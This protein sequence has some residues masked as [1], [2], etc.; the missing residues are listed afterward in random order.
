M[1]SLVGW[2]RQ[3]IGLYLD[4]EGDPAAE[5]LRFQKEMLG[6]DDFR[7][8][9]AADSFTVDDPVYSQSYILAE[10][11][12]KQILSAIRSQVEGPLWPNPRFAGWLT[13]NWLRYGTRH[14]WIPWDKEVTGRPFGA[15]AF[16]RGRS[17]D[18]SV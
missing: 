13:E 6:F 4:P 18:R 12:D 17:F 11:F 14:D 9:S 10:L 15:E 3:E 2:V 8:L 1:V 5:M 16:V 7:P